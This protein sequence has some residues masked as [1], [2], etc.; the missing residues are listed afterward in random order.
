MPPR[1]Y[2]SR[3]ARS[4]A[5]T[6]P[7][8]S[9]ASGVTEIP[10]CSGLRLAGDFSGGP[11]GFGDRHL[12]LRLQPFAAQQVGDDR[13]RQGDENQRGDI[14]LLQPAK[15]DGVVAE[16]ED[17]ELAHRVQDQVEHREQPLGMDSLAQTPQ[18]EKERKADQQ[19]IEAG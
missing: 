2:P 17:E 19:L 3:S 12:G 16:E 4:T 15:D 9:A 8:R 5:S 1:S 11:L 18:E 6:M 10:N 14:G 7:C 13:Q